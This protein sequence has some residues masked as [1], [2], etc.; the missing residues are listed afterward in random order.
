VK[1]FEGFELPPCGR[2]VV[3]KMVATLP[4]LVGKQRHEAVQVSHEGPEAMTRIA[5]W[6]T[7]RLRT[8][9]DI[10]IMVI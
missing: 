2:S 9:D 4:T 8:S 1:R 3:V 5:V 6:K 7:I 10:T